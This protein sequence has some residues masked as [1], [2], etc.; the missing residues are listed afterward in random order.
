MG[1]DREL[2]RAIWR[3]RTSARTAQTSI[4]WTDTGGIYREETRAL[5][6]GQAVPVFVLTNG[7]ASRRFLLTNQAGYSLTYDGLVTAVEK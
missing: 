7:T 2:G 3:S 5:A 1:V 6:D 4:G